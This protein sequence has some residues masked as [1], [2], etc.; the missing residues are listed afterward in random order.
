MPYLIYLQVHAQTY[1]LARQQANL[2]EIHWEL[3]KKVL[4]YLAG[5]KNLGIVIGRDN[6]TF[7]V[8]LDA[9]FVSTVDRKSTSG[10]VILHNSNPVYWKSRAQRIRSD[11]SGISE[12]IALYD[13]A[14]VANG[15]LNFYSDLFEVNRFTVPIYCDASTSVCMA[16]TLNTNSCK[17]IHVKYLYIKEYVNQGLFEIVKIGKDEQLA[18]LLTKPV[19][20]DI[21][22]TLVP[23]SMN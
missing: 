15:I 18:N 23:R 5:T 10:C 22:Q 20:T 9:S 16:N 7:K 8:F 11:S 19:T 1:E 14:K 2:S 21:F 4:R 6:S 3:V 12:Y 17:Y 13:A